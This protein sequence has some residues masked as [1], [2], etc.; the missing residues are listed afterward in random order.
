MKEVMVYG[1]LS[2]LS[3]RLGALCNGWIETRYA[4]EKVLL[5]SLLVFSVSATF[6]IVSE[7]KL[8]FYVFGLIS[9]SLLGPIQSASRT[10]MSRLAPLEQRTE[11]FGFF[12]LSGKIT[13]FLGPLLMS[14]VTNMTHSQRWGM[15]S[16][17]FL[18]LMGAIVFS[19]FMLIQHQNRSK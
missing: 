14:I 9:A 3:A 8:M 17:L 15:S 2:Q 12:S 19:Y 10:L 1:V 11:M 18:F 4:S 7:Q 16:S 13:A 6:V 5:I